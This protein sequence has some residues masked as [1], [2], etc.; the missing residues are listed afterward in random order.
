MNKE[1]N[2]EEHKFKSGL[3]MDVSKCPSCKKPRAQYPLRNAGPPGDDNVEAYN[4]AFKESGECCNPEC[5]GDWGTGCWHC[6]SPEYFFHSLSKEGPKCITDGCDN[7]GTVYR[8]YG[9]KSLVARCPDCDDVLIGETPRETKENKEEDINTFIHDERHIVKSN[10]GQLRGAIES[11]TDGPHGKSKTMARRSAKSLLRSSLSVLSRLEDYANERK[12]IDTPII[13]DFLEGVKREAAHQ[14]GRWGSD[15]D[16]R[17]DH[18]NWLFLIGHLG[19]KAL[20][21]A[22]AGDKDKAMHHTITTAAALYNWHDAIRNENNN[23]KSK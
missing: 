18:G 14:R 15:H 6:H 2:W 3:V 17:K 1:I 4:K 5:G 10:I 7:K 23:A 21:S 9:E 13:D 19:S 16:K 12:Q 20:H 8:H 22:I 11:M